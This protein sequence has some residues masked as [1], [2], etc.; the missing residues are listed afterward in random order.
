MRVVLFFVFIFGFSSFS[1]AQTE[2]KDR[3]N[4]FV[5]NNSLFILYHEIGHLLISE[6]D[7]PILGREENVADNFA[8]LELLKIESDEANNI[9]IDSAD[10][11]FLSSVDQNDDIVSNEAFYAEHALDVQRAYQ[12]V[13][14][15]IGKNKEAFK[16]VAVKLEIDELRQE[17]C[18]YD[19]ILAQESWEKVLKP[20]KKNVPSDLNIRA[21]YD[22]GTGSIAIRKLLQEGKLLENAINGVL[23][24]YNFP[25][26]FNLRAKNCGEANAFYDGWVSELLFCYEL[27]EYFEAIFNEDSLAIKLSD[28]IKTPQDI[29]KDIFQPKK[30]T[31]DNIKD[32]DD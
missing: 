19:Y 25:N 16:Q 12:I 3:T 21:F 32:N 28:P 18:Y 10:G 14:L 5:F 8:T 11:W 13:C 4:E 2:Q 22:R 6:L 17:S 30:K 24:E 7:I 26:K 15:M 31:S 1:F 23:R 9:L 29:E 20:H 27:A